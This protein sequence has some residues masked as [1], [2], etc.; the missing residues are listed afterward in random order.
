M[1]PAPIPEELAEALEHARDES[2]PT[3]DRMAAAAA[4]RDMLEGWLQQI[5]W[6]ARQ[7]GH[8]W[9]QVGSRLG[10]S[11]QAAHQRFGK[12]I[13]V[14]GE[15]HVDQGVHKIGVEGDAHEEIGEL[16]EAIQK[17][18]HKHTPNAGDEIE[19]RHGGDGGERTVEVRVRKQ[20]RD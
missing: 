13:V 16:H 18:L 7:E 3:L 20:K 8:S 11:K 5:A 19:I 2:K 14:R 15:H 12:R 10:T 4:A 1:T 9:A 6:H 17:V